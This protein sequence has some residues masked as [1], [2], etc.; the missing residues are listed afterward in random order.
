[1]KWREKMPQYRVG[2]LELVQKIEERA[3]GVAGLALAG[4]GYRGVGIPYCVRS[5]D[6]AAR[7]VT[8]RFLS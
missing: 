5:G 8:E 1:V 6:E 3:A 2:H 4:N 7:R